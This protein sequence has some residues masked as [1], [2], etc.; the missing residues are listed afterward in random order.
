MKNILLKYLLFSRRSSPTASQSGFSLIEMMVVT[1]MIGIL[2]AIAAGAWEGFTARQRIR[3]VNGQV[4]DALRSAQSDAKMKKETRTVIFFVDDND[5]TPKQITIYP[6]K[7]PSFPVDPTSTDNVA[8]RT[9]N[10][11]S[12]GQIKKGQVKMTFKKGTT[13]EDINNEKVSAMSTNP[14]EAVKPF[15]VVRFDYLGSVVVDSSLPVTPIT[16]TT[17]TP[18][19]GMKRCIIVETLLGGMRSAQGDQCP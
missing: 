9:I 1:I 15:R 6:R 8:I 11:S 12:D 13:N 16:I 4:F 3:T 2:S 7:G 19:N 14:T 18:Q 10:L 5:A 17:S